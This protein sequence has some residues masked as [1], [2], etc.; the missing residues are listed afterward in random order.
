MLTAPI[1]QAFPRNP[2][3]RRGMTSSEEHDHDHT[4]L[5]R[6]GS[7]LRLAGLAAG[8]G[9][10]TALTRLADPDA[11]AAGPLAVRTGS[12]ACV[13]TPELT[14]G[15][16]Y[17]AGERLR[18]DITE[19]RKGVALTLAV[20]VLNASTCTPIKN[21]TVEIW[22]CDAHGVYSG[23]VAGRPGTN[24]L[25]GAQRTNANG[26]AT[27][28]TIFPGWYPGRAVH[29]HVKVHMGGQV[30]HTGQLFFPAATTLAVY[31]RAPYASHG[32]APDTTNASDA[33]YR[34]GGNRGMVTIARRA[35]G[36]VASVAAGVH[37]A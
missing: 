30:V 23:A 19:G 29:I 21:A 16:Y 11:S 6:R 13:L 27:F 31:K 4:P 33:I 17:V 36:Y 34:N 20:T 12:V 1:S 8:V 14:E 5:T 18:R 2:S 25:R 24:F 7:L 15:P 26:V 35:K 37:V 28:D 32:S 22:H 9:G 10:A 3:Y